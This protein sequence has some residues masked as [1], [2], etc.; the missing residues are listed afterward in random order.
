MEIYTRRTAG[1]SPRSVAGGLSRAKTGVAAVTGTPVLQRMNVDFRS[2]KEDFSLS[3]SG[4][5]AWAAKATKKLKPEEGQSRGHIIEWNTRQRAYVNGL[6]ALG[7]KSKVISA[8]GLPNGV[9]DGD[10]QHAIIGKLK[11]LFNDLE[12]LTIN[13]SKADNEAG[14]QANTL[15]QK[16]DGEKNGK[17]RLLLLKQL[18]QYSFN[19]GIDNEGMPK[20]DEYVRTFA[21]A[22]GVDEDDVKQWDHRL[23]DKTTGKEEEKKTGVEK[24]EVT[25][26]LKRKLSKKR[27]EGAESSGDE[28]ESS[29]PVRVTPVSVEPAPKE[30]SKK[31]GVGHKTKS[32]RKNQKRKKKKKLQ[33]AQPRSDKI[34][35][36]KNRTGLP[37][38]LKT[39]VERLSGLSLDDVK[40]HYNSDKPSQLQASAYA[41]GTDIHIGPGQKRHLPHE[42]WH[43]VQQKHGRVRP[44]LQAKNVAIN[45]DKGLEK[46]ADIMGAKALRKPA[47]SVVQKMEDPKKWEK[48]SEP[49]ISER[50][51]KAGMN[52]GRAMLQTG[53]VEFLNRKG[54]IAGPIGASGSS[55]AATHA[56]GDELAIKAAKNKAVME[57]LATRQDFSSSV[58]RSKEAVIHRQEK[59]M[60]AEKAKDKADKAKAYNPR[61]KAKGAKKKAQKEAARA[62]EEAREREKL[63]D[64]FGVRDTGNTE[65]PP[66]S[67]TEKP[68]KEE[69]KKAE[70]ETK[71]KADTEWL[72]YYYWVNK[73]AFSGNKEYQP[74]A[75]KEKA[76][77]SSVIEQGWTLGY[78]GPA[79]Y[80][81]DYD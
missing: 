14:A 80:A 36:K 30:E 19:P 15:A 47:S 17:K 75:R 74:D 60:E 35:L 21:Q 8:L 54:H 59:E 63:N 52:A 24:K 26:G 79:N 9:P 51:K 43:V 29:E 68:K 25:G 58:V 44:T 7:T 71:Q 61:K 38:Q 48:K 37:D 3:A 28:D 33:H 50:Q 40:V 55:R 32:Q 76:I 23:K 5:P 1:N 72:D 73:A 16:I 57:G 67:K 10:I 53:A 65:A 69:S 78:E 41:H 20:W 81:L 22:W 11:T 6:K 34:Q 12:N 45:D 42:A 27:K 4:R 62:A 77:K 13:D 18:F 49:D 66:E 56:H 2:N 64:L 70:A 39:G 46:E 31:P